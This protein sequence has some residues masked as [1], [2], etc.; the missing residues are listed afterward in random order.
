MEMSDNQWSLVIGAAIV[1][2]TRAV[3]IFLPKGYMARMVTKYLV[4][5]PKDDEEK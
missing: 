4:K 1:I 5:V 2:V 3:D